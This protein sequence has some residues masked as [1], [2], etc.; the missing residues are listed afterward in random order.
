[1]AILKLL[2]QG[3]LELLGESGDSYGPQ[4]ILHSVNYAGNVS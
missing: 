4:T 3:G 2:Q 1:M